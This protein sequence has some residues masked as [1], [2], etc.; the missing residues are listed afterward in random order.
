VIEELKQV[1]SKTLIVSRRMGQYY[2][3]I[4]VKAFSKSSTPEVLNFLQRTVKDLVN[5]VILYQTSFLCGAK[6]VKTVL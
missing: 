5:W 1:G 4:G 2:L 3:I 6:A